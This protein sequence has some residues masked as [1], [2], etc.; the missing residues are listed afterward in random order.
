MKRNGLKIAALV[1]ALLLIVGAVLFANSLVGNPISKALAK[2][3]AKKYMEEAYGDTDYELERVTYSF[4]DGYYHAFVSSPTGK[5]TYFTLLI[6]GFGKLRYDNYETSV[7][8]G[9]NTASRLDADYRK[10][11]DAIMDSSIFPYDEHIGYGDLVCIPSENR[12][13]EGVPE[14]ALITDDLTLDAYYNVSELGAKAGKLTV[15]IEDETVST[16]RAAEILV[17]IRECFDRAGV[18][19]YAI[20]L[21]LE[22]PRDEN[23]YSEDG[24]VEL[25]DFRYADIYEEGLAERVRISD[26]ATR[27]YYS[28]A[29]AEKLKEQP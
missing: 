29:D 22:Y 11:V 25:M 17:G 2:H 21:V 13:A 3:T 15:Y 24:R 8:N 28:Y 7:A 19:F 14:Y 5:D 27:A 1:V 10:A 16:E 6:N 23:G 26:E 20:D 18:G 4:K 9:W 12:N